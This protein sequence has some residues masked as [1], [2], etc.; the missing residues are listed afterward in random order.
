MVGA[1][2]RCQLLHPHQSES[3]ACIRSMIREKEIIVKQNHYF[4]ENTQD[5]SCTKITP[6][7]L[8]WKIN[9]DNISFSKHNVIS[10]H[11]SSM[12]HNRIILFDL[13][14][15]V[16]NWI[17]TFQASSAASSGHDTVPT[18]PPSALNADVVSLFAAVI[19]DHEPW[20]QK[21]THRM[22]GKGDRETEFPVA[23]L[24]SKPKARTPVV[25]TTG[26]LSVSLKKH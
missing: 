10:C 19:F 11:C 25:P 9:F 12:T 3:W 2:G 6:N 5:V 22:T 21:P 16:K 4:T 20:E 17:P 14:Y 7:I 18:C 23:F 26:L 1:V 24:S 8:A 15:Q 13:H